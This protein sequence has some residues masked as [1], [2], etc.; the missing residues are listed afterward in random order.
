MCTAPAP[1]TARPAASTTWNGST[2]GSGS[3]GRFAAQA[4]R[5]RSLMSGLPCCSQA[6]SA[7]SISFDRQLFRGGSSGSW[8]SSWRIGW[9]WWW[10]RRRFNRWWWLGWWN[11]WWSWWRNRR[12]PEWRLKLSSL[13]WNHWWW[14]QWTGSKGLWLWW[15]AL[16]ESFLDDTFTRIQPITAASTLRG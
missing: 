8:G 1:G 10:R 2:T 9:C 3:D 15:Y 6:A 4:P 7:R 14:I 12:W 5:T 13:Y 11:Q 16:S